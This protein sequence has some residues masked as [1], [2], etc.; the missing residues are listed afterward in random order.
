MT[1]LE[2]PYVSD[3]EVVEEIKGFLTAYPALKYEDVV[4]QEV[5]HH[6]GEDF[7]LK[8]FIILPD[9]LVPEGAEELEAFFKD[10]Y[11]P[12][13]DGINQGRKLRQ[14]ARQRH[15]VMTRASFIERSTYDQQKSYWHIRG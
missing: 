15:Y 13:S 8:I 3:E 6:M 4:V 11:Q 12:V 14:A 9:G 2:E 10:Y 7:Y 1:T 5:R